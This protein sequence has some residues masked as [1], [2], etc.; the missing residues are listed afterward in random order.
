MGGAPAGLEQPSPSEPVGPT[1]EVLYRGR[2]MRLFR[3][4]GEVSAMQAVIASSLLVG[5]AVASTTLWYYSRRYVGELS[6]LRDA[7]GCPAKARFSVLDFW[8]NRED[9]EV[10]LPAIVPPLQGVLPQVRASML[11]EM[12][13]PV[14]VEGDRQY[15]LSLRY[16]FIVDKQQ[17]RDLLEGRLGQQEQPSEGQLPV[18]QGESR[19][20]SLL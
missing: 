14:D 15:Y 8:G 4:L 12:L 5:S 3:L 20:T 7:A 1:K 13:I 16:G 6:L 11:Q 18:A 10:Q 19:K 2:G 17:L 9:I